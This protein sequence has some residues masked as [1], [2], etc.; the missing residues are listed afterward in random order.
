[1]AW[2]RAQEVLGE[3]REITGRKIILLGNEQ[4]VCPGRLP[5]RGGI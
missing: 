5:G 1:M 3:M 4:R 2:M